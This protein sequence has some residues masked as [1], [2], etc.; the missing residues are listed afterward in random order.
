MLSRVRKVLDVLDDPSMIFAGIFRVDGTP[1][2][3]RCKSKVEV[4]KIVDWLDG[5][6]KSSLN[7]LLSENLNEVGAKFRR[8]YT[9]I[10]PL[11]KILVLVLVSTDEMSLYKF[12]IDI[13]SLKHLLS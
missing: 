10:V 7:L 1:V 5:H 11:S 3:V 2:M 4:L 9:R 13:A 8:V 6:I 12:D